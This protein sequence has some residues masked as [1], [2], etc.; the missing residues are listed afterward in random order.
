MSAFVCMELF[1]KLDA[2]S[3][4]IELTQGSD[5]M[6]VQV[7]QLSVDQVDLLSG[8][9]QEC[10]R[11]FEHGRTSNNGTDKSHP[12]FCDATPPAR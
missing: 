2:K 4:I 1:V 11:E 9:L 6:P 12:G 10:K 7:I 5:E 3:G 8:W